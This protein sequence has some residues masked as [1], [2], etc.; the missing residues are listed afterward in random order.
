MYGGNLA[1]G[2]LFFE[3]VIGISGLGLGFDRFGWPL[4]LVVAGVLLVAGGLS[5]RRR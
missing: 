4:A 5:Y 1:S 2:S 3:L